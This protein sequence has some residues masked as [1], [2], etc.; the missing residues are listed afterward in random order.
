MHET[1]TVESIFG[2]GGESDFYYY[3]PV[4]F[5]LKLVYGWKI[6]LKYCSST[7]AFFIYPKHV[8]GS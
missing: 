4:F 7:I 1:S 8:Y 2:G 6:S 5:I 3:R